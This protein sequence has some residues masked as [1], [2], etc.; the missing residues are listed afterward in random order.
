MSPDELLVLGEPFRQFQKA[1]S[2]KHTGTGL[3]VSL[4]KS[5]AELHGGRLEY[6]SE[7]GVGTTATLVLPAYRVLRTTIEMTA[8]R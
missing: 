6:I 2:R 3:G 1:Y 7:P 8:D 4:S 5:L